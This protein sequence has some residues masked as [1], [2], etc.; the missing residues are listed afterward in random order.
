MP[1]RH[2]LGAYGF[3]VLVGDDTDVRMAMSG[4]CRFRAHVHGRR[5]T[6]FQGWQANM[7]DE[8][9]R[10]R[11]HPFTPRTYPLPL[12]CLP[13]YPATYLS[14]TY[15]PT[16]LPTN[17]LPT[18]L[19]TH[20]PTYLPTHLPTYTPRTTH[21]ITHAPYHPCTL[22]S[23]HPTIHPSYHAPTHRG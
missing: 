18:C 11:F 6:F 8:V 17:P 22:P 15:L 9:C 10:D 12:P 4:F 14:P 13:I 7:F 16:Y 2:S 23:T 20:L 21:P 5:Q 1:T 3:R 19:S